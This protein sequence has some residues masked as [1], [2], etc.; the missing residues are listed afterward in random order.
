[1]CGKVEPPKHHRKA[2]HPGWEPVVVAIG[3]RTGAP[4]SPGTGVVA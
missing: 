2:R 3:P 1:V 4:T